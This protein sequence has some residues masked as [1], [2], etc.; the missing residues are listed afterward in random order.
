M[1]SGFV[2]AITVTLVATLLAAT[3][4]VDAN[5]T[6]GQVAAGN[7]TIT[8]APG[9][10]TV[11]QLT[12][13][14][15]INWQTFSIGVGEITK[16]VQ[17]SSTSAALNRVL[18]GQMS[19]I[20]GTLSG[21]GQVYLLNGNGI[22][23]GP[24]GVVNTAGFTAS[25]RN[26]SDADF[27][28]GNLHFT[29][30]SNGGVTNLGQVSALGGDVIFIG[31]TV[32]NQGELNAPAGHVGLA[33][34]DDVMISQAGMEH[35]FVRSTANPTSASGLTAVNNSGSVIAASA[36]LKAANGNIYALATN[37]S[38]IVRATGVKNQDGHIWLVAQGN[39]GVTQNTGT[40]AARG[41][42]GQGGDI[43]TSGGKVVALGTVDAGNGG[44]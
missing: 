36:E 5:P 42:N 2:R 23:I 28:S 7:A 20:N 13:K 19:I 24:G 11:N 35:V 14:T 29:G 38:G 10:V 12:D 1:K 26:L 30:S 21:N 34:A 44:T 22:L 43:E 17:P 4:S 8:T 16:F 9:V 27:A 39:Q 31:K 40:L 3:T 32:D 33:A 25:T 18:G 41:A 15:V 6:D 37:N